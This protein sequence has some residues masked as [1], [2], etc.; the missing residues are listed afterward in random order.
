M[1]TSQL[2]IIKA[3][4]TSIE[5]IRKSIDQSADSTVDVHTQAPDVVNRFMKLLTPYMDSR[6]PNNEGW[7]I[8]DIFVSDDFP[9]F[10]AAGKLTFGAYPDNILLPNGK[11]VWIDND[12]DDVVAKYKLGYIY[13][14]LTVDI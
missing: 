7:G 1:H 13:V 9:F 2:A 6:F 11:W 12:A 14:F 5:N 4:P 8:I 10:D 3:S